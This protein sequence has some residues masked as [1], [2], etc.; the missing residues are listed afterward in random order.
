MHLLD[1]WYQ[2]GWEPINKEMYASAYANWGGSL[3]THPDFIEKMSD[4]VSIMPRHF[5]YFDNKHLVA[6]VATWGHFI[7]GDKRALKK[8]R[9]YHDVDLGNMEIIL[10][11]APN[12]KVPL[13]F[14]MEG[15]SA[16]HANQIHHLKPSP[17]TFSF[18]KDLHHDVTRKFLYNRKRELRLLHDNGITLTPLSNFSPDEIGNHYRTLFEKR[19]GKPPRAAHNINKQL[20]ALKDYLVGFMLHKADKAIAV[21]LLFCTETNHH[22]SI[23]YINGGVDPDYSHLSPGSVLTF[24]NA[25]WATQFASQKNKSLRYSFG[26]SDQEYKK[27]WCNPSSVYR[28]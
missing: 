27:M 25:E 8:H 14:K 22:I 23:E 5:G 26:L 24:A 21:Q 11:I 15:L 1:W 20:S 7:A 13:G 19:W 9:R 6:A 12:A 4:L 2:K 28:I 17:T 16:L 3:A 10:P 18:L